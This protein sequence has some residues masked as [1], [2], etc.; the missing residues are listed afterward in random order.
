MNSNSTWTG[1]VPV[2]DTAPA[3]TDTCGP[4]RGVVYLNGS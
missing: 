4:G 2:E 3:V 1:L